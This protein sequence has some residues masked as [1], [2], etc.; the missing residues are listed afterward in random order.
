MLFPR[1]LIIAV[2]AVA[3]TLPVL[4]VGA[5]V[6]RR[7]G[8]AP[9]PQTSVTSITIQQRMIVRVPRLPPGPAPAAAAPSLPPL[10]WVEKKTGKCVPL[11]D[12]AAATVASAES[13]DLILNGGRRLRASFGSECR[14]L[15]FY[16]GFYV[17]M[18]GDRKVCAGRDS[19]RAR[20][21][22]ECRIKAF[23]ALVP[24]R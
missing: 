11:I 23:R 9:S 22:G 3:T 16:S 19:F 15:D 13:V 20:S 5:Q 17:K 6:A 2:A 4:A 12:L 7:A 24:K 14:A 10:R 8:A 18:T 1:L 21:G